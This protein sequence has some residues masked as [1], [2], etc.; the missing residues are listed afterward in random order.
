MHPASIVALGTAL[1]RIWGGFTCLGGNF[2]LG[3]PPFYGNPPCGP[4]IQ[5]WKPESIRSCQEA[6]GEGSLAEESEQEAQKQ[7]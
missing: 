1:I 5:V 3:D 2:Y 7:H 4:I 6:Q